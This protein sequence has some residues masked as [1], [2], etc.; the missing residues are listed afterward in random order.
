MESSPCQFPPMIH[1]FQSSND[2]TILIVP[3]VDS[4]LIALKE[5]LDVFY[6]S[7]GLKVNFQKSTMVPLN[8][9]NEAIRLAAVFG[10]S[11]GT[12]PFTYLGLPMGTTKPRIIDLLPLV[13][14]MERRLTASSAMLNQG[15][16]LQLLTSVLSSMPIYFICTLDIPIG[17][18]KQLER[19]Q[20][21]CLWRGNS[22]TPK[23]SLAAWE[24]VCRPKDKGGLG[25][26]NLHLQNQGLL[27]K[28]LHKFFNKEDI[29]WVSLIWNS[30]Y[31]GVVPQAMIL[32]GSFWWRDVFKLADSY[33]AIST[34]T[35]NQGDSILFWSDS[36][37]L[38]NSNRPLRDRLPH[39]FSFVKDDKI[40][41]MD[42]LDSEDVTSMFHL[43]ISNTA[44]SELEHLLHWVTMLHRDAAAPDV[45][46]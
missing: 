26:I 12:L 30:Y 27:I 32:C 21:Q 46:S 20:R 10:C 17:I 34:A 38:H 45:W 37:I 23:Q 6:A 15:S 39:L 18:I 41:A 42:F 24:L 29:P 25:I 33:R 7:T 22:D 4:Q 5:M 28:H 14:R 1:I 11:L 3:A 19:I 2:D 35:V 16:R 31:D 8:I 40:S 13:D 9:D 36:W 44:A 43:P